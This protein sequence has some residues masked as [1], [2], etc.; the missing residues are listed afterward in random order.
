MDREQLNELIRCAQNK[1]LVV[2]PA[3]K[4]RQRVALALVHAGYLIPKSEQNNPA[5]NPGLLS[6]VY[7]VTL[8]LTDNG[9]AFLLGLTP[10]DFKERIW[11][12]LGDIEQ[13]HQRLSHD[14]R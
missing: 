7:G 3:N 10:A 8:T 13:I 12:K 6:N 2:R 14:R 11:P 9:R 4:Y 5:F 1:R